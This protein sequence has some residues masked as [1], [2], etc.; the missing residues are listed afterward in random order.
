KKFGGERVVPGNIIVRQR[1][2]QWHPGD[3]VG[4]GTD[5]TLF[6]VAEVHVEFRTKAKERVYV[7]VRP[8][9]LEAAESSR[10]ERRWLVEGR[11]Q[12]ISLFWCPDGLARCIP[13]AKR[14]STSDA[15]PWS[16][17]PRRTRLRLVPGSASASSPSGATGTA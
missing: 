6:A 7:S 12:A 1:G 5:H 11:W 13:G 3:N 16:I 17:A 14:S 15:E 2:T 10:A 4:M 8:P 9:Q